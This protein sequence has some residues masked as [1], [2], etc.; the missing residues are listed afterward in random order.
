MQLRIQLTETCSGKKVH[1]TRKKVNEHDA[2][3]KIMWR[4]ELTFRHMFVLY[5]II[6]V[7]SILVCVM[8]L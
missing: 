6:I 5:Y 3:T 7:C 1:T 8:F 2:C 4:H